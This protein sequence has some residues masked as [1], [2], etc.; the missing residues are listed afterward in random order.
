MER[1]EKD[2]E[3]DPAFRNKMYVLMAV[4]LL[5]YMG[6]KTYHVI[7]AFKAYEGQVLDVNTQG[8]AK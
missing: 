8:A 6:L 4:L 5:G 1:A 7:T 2:I 3:K